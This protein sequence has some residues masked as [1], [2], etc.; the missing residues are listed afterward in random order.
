MPDPQIPD[1]AIIIT[2]AEV[3]AEVRHLTKAVDE[4]VAQNKADETP[5]KVKDL[6]TR[7]R[8]LEQKVWVAAGFAAAFGSGV[9]SILTQQLGR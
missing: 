5:A 4:L 7:V 2:P 8:S 9:G 3:Y 1:G 6:E